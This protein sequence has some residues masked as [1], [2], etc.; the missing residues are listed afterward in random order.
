MKIILSNEISRNIEILPSTSKSL[1]K[2]ILGNF[3]FND[4]YSDN[5]HD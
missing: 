3:N 2:G 4:V 5:M 1:A